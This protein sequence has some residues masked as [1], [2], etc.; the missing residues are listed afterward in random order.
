MEVLDYYGCDPAGRRRP[1]AERVIGRPV[2]M[3]LQ[4][5]NATVTMCHP[6]T[7]T[8]AVCGRRRS[9]GAPP[10]GQGRRRYRT[11]VLGVRISVTGGRTGRSW[12]GRHPD[13]RGCYTHAGEVGRRARSRPLPVGR[14]RTLSCGPW[15]W[16]SSSVLG[17]YRIGL[18]RPPVSGGPAKKRA[19]LHMNSCHRAWVPACSGRSTISAG[20]HSRAAD[21]IW[22]GNLAG[23]GR[24]LRPCG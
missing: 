6:R 5:R 18:G 3:L 23:A 11:V 19:V 16:P 17:G 4:R 15:R 24:W 21:L 20:G 9:G 12:T 22:L 8:A 2:S 13:H 14:R 7:A 10:K 1:S